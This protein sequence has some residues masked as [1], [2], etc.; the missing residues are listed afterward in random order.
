MFNTENLLSG[1]LSWVEKMN[2]LG[3][4]GIPF[5]FIID[6]EMQKPQIIKIKD[7]GPDILYKCNEIK[8][9]QLTGHISKPLH[10]DKEPIDY[11]RFCTAFD[12][13]KK[14]IQFGNSF[15][16]NLT[17]PTQIHTNYTLKELFN[18]AHARYKLYYKDE[19]IVFSPEIFV[20]IRENK[21][22]TFPMKGTIDASIPDAKNIILNNLK[23]TAEHYTI[24]DLLRNDLSTVARNVTVNRFRYIDQLKTTHK[25]LLQV[26]SEI[27]GT[28]PDDFKEHIGDIISRLL[29]AGSI[30]GAPKKK[31]IDIINKS[32]LDDRGYYTGVFGIFDGE[33]LDSG[34]MIRFI[35]KKGDQLIYRSGCGITNMSDSETEYNEMRDKVYVP[36]DRKY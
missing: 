24:V 1:K 28:L 8:N 34:V 21:I 31:T 10:F 17:F 33:N 36:V 35:E 14:E 19:F 16:L 11:K 32:E 22:Y 27:E 13:V 20:Q 12:Q 26:S 2:D 9:Y 29:P 3:K 15:L 7:I 18:T 30:S 5:I 4:K 25:T 23:E 6:F